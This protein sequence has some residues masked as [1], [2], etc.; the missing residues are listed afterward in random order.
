MNRSANEFECCTWVFLFQISM[1]HTCFRLCGPI[2]KMNNM[3][4]LMKHISLIKALLVS[5]RGPWSLK[6][7]EPKLQHSNSF[8]NLF[9][10]KYIHTHTYIYI[11]SH[12]QTDCFI[13]SE[14]FSVARPAGRSKPG[15]KPI[16]LYDR[17]RFQTTRLQAD[18]VG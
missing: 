18:Y 3:F 17:L 4:V 10:L 11:Y 7:V 9:I 1:L 2:Q 6:C 14:L 13:L 12:P 15:S 8:A 16:Q 5:W